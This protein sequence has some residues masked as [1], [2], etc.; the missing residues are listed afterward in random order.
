MERRRTEE[1][2]LD[3]SELLTKVRELVA[4]GNV[5]RIIIKNEDGHTLIEVPLTL[6][7]IGALLL[8]VWAAIGAIAALATRCTIVVERDEPTA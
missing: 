4:E 1:F 8:P 7:V 6:G 3:G 5:R 2:R